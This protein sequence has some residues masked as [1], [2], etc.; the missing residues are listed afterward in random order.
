MV[1]PTSPIGA[2]DIST[3]RR[4]P[5]GSSGLRE[6]KRIIAVIHNTSIAIATR[7][8]LV[9]ISSFVRITDKNIYKSQ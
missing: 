3:F 4:L 5:S 2:L 9:F 1:G 8:A 6:L 7:K